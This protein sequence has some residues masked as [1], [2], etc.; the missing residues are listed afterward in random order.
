MVL[1]AGLSIGGVSWLDRERELRKGRYSDGAVIV[2]EVLSRVFLPESTLLCPVLLP[3]QL[4]LPLLGAIA[5]LGL[6]LGV[7]INASVRPDKPSWASVGVD[8]KSPKE[9]VDRFCS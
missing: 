5:A 3:A 6:N 8:E 7:S 9:S 2:D 4:T 1:V